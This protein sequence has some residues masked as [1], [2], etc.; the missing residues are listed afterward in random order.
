MP[1]VFDFRAIEEYITITD[2]QFA[3]KCKNVC[4]PMLFQF[5]SAAPNSKI[6]F[7][8]QKSL[9]KSSRPFRILTRAIDGVQD[10]VYHTLQ[11]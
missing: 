1:V 6:H 8:Y 10:D 9:N 7:L 5:I 2:L 4:R 3:I 11:L